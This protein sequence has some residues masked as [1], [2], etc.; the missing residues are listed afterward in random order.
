MH[1]CERG[2][3]GGGG[4]RGMKGRKRE[5]ERERERENMRLNKPN[6]S[7]VTTMDV[8]LVI[9]TFLLTCLMF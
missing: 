8:A 7:E 6:N 4:G 1:V 5:R 2:G 3:G 9:N